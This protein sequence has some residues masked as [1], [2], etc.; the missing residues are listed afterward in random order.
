MDGKMTGIGVDDRSQ[1]VHSWLL[2]LQIVKGRFR[3]LFPVT[4][5]DT[6]KG[7]LAFS[8]PMF[9]IFLNYSDLMATWGV[10]LLWFEIKQIAALHIANYGVAIMMAQV[11]QWFSVLETICF[12]IFLELRVWSSF[13]LG[14]KIK[15]PPLA[16]S[17]DGLWWT[18]TPELLR[19]R[20]H[21][22]VFNSLVKDQSTSLYLFHA[23]LLA[24]NIR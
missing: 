4:K 5:T 11:R 6:L 1:S 2:N 15:H 3:K 7:I 14:S 16:F 23:T 13:W 21:L 19:F 24:T 12:H 9:Q 18:C 10:L 8:Q 22:K 17:G 20:Y